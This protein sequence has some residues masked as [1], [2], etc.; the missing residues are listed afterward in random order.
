MNEIKA[1][2]LSVTFNY[3]LYYTFSDLPLFITTNEN[4]IISTA[5]LDSYIL[6]GERSL[7]GETN[8]M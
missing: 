8:V 4:D 6:R 7:C 5:Y 2:F 3:V 1:M